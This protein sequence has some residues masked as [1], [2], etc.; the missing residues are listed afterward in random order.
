MVDCF[1]DDFSLGEFDDCGVCNGNNEDQDCNGDCFGD[2]IIDDCGVC[3][4]D[5]QEDI[6][7]MTRI[8]MV[9]VLEML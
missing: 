3:E 4:L 1:E 7:L 2:S 5:C 8:V 9:I 6:I